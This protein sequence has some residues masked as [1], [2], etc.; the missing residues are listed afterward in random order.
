LRRL[1]HEAF[2]A[3]TELAT[4]PGRAPEHALGPRQ[5]ERLEREID[6]FDALA[7]PL[8]N[9]VLPTGIPAAAELHVL[10]TVARRAEREI[11]ALHRL[12]PVPTPLLEWVNRLSDLAFALARAVNHA[13]GVPE[14]A[15][16]YDA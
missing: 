13:A 10:R 7:P 6:R 8:R 4:P 12:E 14:I 1:Q 5:V 15:P 16:E 2:T 9:F 3:M 11:V